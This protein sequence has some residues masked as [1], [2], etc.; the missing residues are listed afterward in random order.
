MLC[1]VL[2]ALLPLMGSLEAGLLRSCKD[3]GCA[4]NAKQSISHLFDHSV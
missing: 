4:Q 1:A 2:F 3:A